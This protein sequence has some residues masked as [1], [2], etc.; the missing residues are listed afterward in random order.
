MTLDY[1]FET[2][3]QDPFAVLFYFLLMPLL[4]AGLNFASRA[5]AHFR[6][7]SYC[8]VAL[9]YLVAIPGVLSATLWVYSALFDSKSL[10]GLNFYIYYAPLLSM[11]GTLYLITRKIRISQLP[12]FSR[13]DDWLIIIALS[14]SSVLFILHLELIP[15]SALWQLGLTFVLFFFLYRTAWNRFQRLS[16]G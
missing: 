10:T 7:W 8:Y 15:Y 13:L 16:R 5:R 6:P 2:I 4:A 1:V 12:S 14:F 9:I 11:A 3:T